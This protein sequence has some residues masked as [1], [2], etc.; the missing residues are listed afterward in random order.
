M[1]RYTRKDRATELL[2]K[3]KEG[4]CFD[5]FGG[6]EYTPAHAKYRYQLWA[7]TWIIGELV[8]LIPELKRNKP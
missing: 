7:S 8:A 2:R 4:P 1:P 6:E 5:H 3:L